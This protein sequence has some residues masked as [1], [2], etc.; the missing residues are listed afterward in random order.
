MSEQELSSEESTPKNSRR[1]ATSEDTVDPKHDLR[2]RLS[3]EREDR[4]ARVKVVA[5]W[6]KVI[7]TA[8][9]KGGKVIKV[10]E[11]NTGNRHNTFVG[12]TK[13]LKN[14]LALWKKQGKLR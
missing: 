6:Y 4:R 11:T 3:Q 7:L 12:F 9:E 14:E 2:V 1:K 10:Q 8:S 13:H 5:E